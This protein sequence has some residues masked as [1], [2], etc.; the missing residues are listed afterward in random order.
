MTTKR[1]P[2]RVKPRGTSDWNIMLDGDV[3]WI[4]DLVGSGVVGIPTLQ[5][6]ELIETLNDAIN[7][8]ARVVR[9]DL[10]RDRDRPPYSRKSGKVV[11]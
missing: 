5:V 9:S 1:K 3:V 7:H 4:D 10:V 11:G 8:R 2:V 6:P